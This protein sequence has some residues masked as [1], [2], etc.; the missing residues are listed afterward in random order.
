MSQVVS[1]AFIFSNG[2]LSVYLAVGSH[3]FCKQR[4]ADLVQGVQNFPVG[5]EHTRLVIRNGVLLTEGFDD[6]LGFL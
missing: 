1:K 2:G 4:Y 5:L 6:L 3:L